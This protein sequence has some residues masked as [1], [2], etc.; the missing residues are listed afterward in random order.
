MD[1]LSPEV[2]LITTVA[3]LIIALGLVEGMKF[4]VT[5]GCQWSALACAILSILIG[6]AGWVGFFILILERIHTGFN[7]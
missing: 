1:F 2:L 7:P 5:K 3:C 4:A 6:L